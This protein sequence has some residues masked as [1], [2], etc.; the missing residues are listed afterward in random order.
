M[1]LSSYL[2]NRKQYVSIDGCI[3]Q[4]R[5]IS[6]GVP[7]GSV[8]GPLLFLIYIND[9]PRSLTNL[10]AILFADDTT[11]FTSSMNIQQLSNMI[12]DDLREVKNW[13]IANRL[14]L[15]AD[16]TYYMIFS[17]RHIP[18]NTHITLGTA[19]LERK[20]QGKFLGITLDDKL[21]FKGHISTITKKISRLVGLFY[22]LRLSFPLAVLKQLYYSLIYPYLTYC[23][24]IW[25]C[26]AQSHL[27]PLNLS[28][29][30]IIRLLTNSDY[31]AHTSP[32]FKELSI[33]NLKDLYKNQIALTMHKALVQRKLEKLRAEI[34]LLQPNH[35]YQTRET[36]LRLPQRRLQKTEQ[37]LIYQG[38][39]IWNSLPASI[40]NKTNIITFKKH[41]KD[42]FINSY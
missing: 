22:K 42:H 2:T 9:L 29:K 5:A 37:N 36:N 40:K 33:L 18:E 26:T 1:I 16:K 11:L 12:S 15:N 39:L 20:S 19:I 21:T 32:L 25:G 24:P 4:K 31:L 34:L 13:L 14:T 3:S 6:V 10:K 41:L 17:L 27:Q 35:N 7:Q 38:I 8:L 28:L 30:K 23:L